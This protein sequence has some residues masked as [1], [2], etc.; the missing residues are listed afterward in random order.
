MKLSNS[1]IAV[2]VAALLPLA[3]LAGDKDK[4]P[5]PMGTVSSA[6]FA[7]LDTNEDSRISRNE[8]ASDPKI[9]FET[10]D[11][12]ADGYLD[13]NEYLHRDTSKD[14]NP[15]P[16]TQSSVNPDVDAPKPN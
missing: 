5:A 12:N 15:T 6:E 3:A 13:S 1:M 14:S 8:A 9:M 2:A 11:K 4:T 16:R 7:K 10:A